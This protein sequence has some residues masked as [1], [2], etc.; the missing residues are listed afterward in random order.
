MITLEP[1]TLQIVDAGFFTSYHFTFT[2]PFCQP[3][4]TGTTLLV[5]EDNL[6]LAYVQYRHCS[7]T[8]IAIDQ[9][10][11]RRP[12]CGSLLVRH[13]QEK[14]TGISVPEVLKTAIWFW[15]KMGFRPADE[16]IP[17]TY[18]WS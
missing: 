6:V 7:D 18:I 12:G 17:P 14:Y 4:H 5:V 3:G 10:E 13:L 15:T 9:I 11:S 2:F 8:V 16:G 1:T